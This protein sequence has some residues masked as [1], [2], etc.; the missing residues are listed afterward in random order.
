MPISRESEGAGMRKR[1]SRRNLIG[2][3][4]GMLGAATGA[5]RAGAG[6]ALPAAACYWRLERSTCLGGTSQ[7]YWCYRCCDLYGCRDRYCEWRTV[8]SC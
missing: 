6:E 3:V 4:V 1:F 7:E 2:M 8:G 5:N